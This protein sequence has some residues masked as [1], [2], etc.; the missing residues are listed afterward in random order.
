[1]KGRK[2]LV[3]LMASLF[4]S[5]GFTMPASAAGST[6]GD[7]M[8]E[9]ITEQE[10]KNYANDLIKDGGAKDFIEDWNWNDSTQ[11]DDEVPLFDYDG[12]INSYLFRLKTNGISQG[13]I[14]VNTISAEAG[15]ESFSDVGEHP[16]DTMAK[17]Q[18]GYST[19]KTDNIINAGILN[20]AVEKK[21]KYIK[22]DTGDQL[23][24][25]YNELKSSY[26]SMLTAT[27]KKKKA[28]SSDQFQI[29]STIPAADSLDYISAWPTDNIYT[30]SYFG[31][32]NN[33]TPTALTNFVYYWGNLHPNKK[34]DLWTGSVYQD[35]KKFVW[36]VPG[37]GPWG[38]SFNFRVIPALT[39]FG[40]SRNIPIV[41]SDSRSGGSIDWN[42]ISSAIHSNIPV[43][44][45]T[46]DDPKY[47][48]HS[49]L[50]IGFNLS[51]KPFLQVIDGWEQTIH[52]VYTYNNAAHLAQAAY[53][54]WV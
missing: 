19:K 8:S 9:F 26:E 51:S 39:E 53:V 20:Y 25:D 37:I 23:D 17:K 24:G 48:N 1:M 27:I 11:I 10:A 3:L 43:V 6:N 36:W 52:T 7:S 40:N 46:T 16:V 38:G 33:C 47:G 44:L 29:N 45:N 31:D 5:I 34:P 12:N 22:L 21:D 2:F 15:V 14:F 28:S 32:P 13:Y 49:I 35:L 18:L 41:N 54:R 4:V 30:M 42:F 50:A